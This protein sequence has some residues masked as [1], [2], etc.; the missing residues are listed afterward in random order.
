MRPG[1][2]RHYLPPI[3]LGLITIAV[4]APAL[5]HR[6]WWIDELITRDISRLPLIRLGSASGT[7]PFTRSILYYT[8][9]DTGPG[10]LMYLLEGMFSRLAYPM[11]GEFWLRIPG[12]AA[13]VTTTILL[14]VALRQRMRLAG[15]LVATAIAAALPMFVE[16]YT[17]AR[18][19]GWLVLIAIAQWH[20]MQRQNSTRHAFAFAAL[21][22]AGLLVNPVH[23]LWT[24]VLVAAGLLAE[25]RRVQSGS[26]RRALS[27]T[28]A[29]VIVILVH[30]AFLGAWIY[31]VSHSQTG[32]ATTLRTASAAITMSRVGHSWPILLLISA[33]LIMGLLLLRLR[34]PAARLHGTICIL[35]AIAN[36]LLLVMLC[37]RFF[38]ATRYFYVLPL[39]LIIGTGFGCDRMFSK[40]RA[41]HGAPSVRPKG[42]SI[43]FVLLLPL[44]WSS[45]EQAAT[46]VQDWWRAADSIKE[47]AQPDDIVLTGPNSEYEVYRVYAQPAGIK[48]QA[49]L[50]I[51]DATRTQHPLDRADGLQ[52]L[53]NRKPN[54][55]LI[56][57]SLN[58]HRTPQYWQLVRD[59]FHVVEHV[60]GRESILI[61]KYSRAKSL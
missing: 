25:W 15:T 47:H 54:I 35:A 50:L 11:G 48:A 3:V 38:P 58:Q 5:H 32:S 19:Y 14:Y 45:A 23:T 22:I 7:T 42:Y 2:L 53:L 17:G 13:G 1:A 31:S 56:T 29:F 12:M 59:N 34:L 4:C 39:C 8:M 20:C 49:P 46:A 37:A 57:A 21:S 36:A 26:H 9:H 55:W 24:A 61:S 6:S 44:S 30:A 27:L 60:P 16:F 18:G 51:E 33:T 43:A 10:P 52:M 28:I 40:L 41:M